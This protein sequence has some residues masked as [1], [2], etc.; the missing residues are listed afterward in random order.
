MKATPEEL[1][2]YTKLQPRWKQVLVIAINGYSLRESAKILG[3]SFWTVNAYLTRAQNQL[4][5]E[6]R[7]L[8]YLYIV[9]RPELEQILRIECYDNIFSNKEFNR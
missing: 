1:M 6:K 3:L 5:F 8:M 2:Q 9:R 4:G 7:I